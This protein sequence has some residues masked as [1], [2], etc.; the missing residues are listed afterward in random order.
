M[1]VVTCVRRLS[2]MLK[3]SKNAGVLLRPHIPVLVPALLEAISGLEPQVMNYLSVR[4]S[5]E[6]TQN[7][8]HS[9]G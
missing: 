4:V 2:T 7:R 1:I 6:E 9:P 8:V 3:I 5:N